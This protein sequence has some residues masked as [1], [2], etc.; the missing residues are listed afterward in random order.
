MVDSSFGMDPEEVYMD[1]RLAIDQLTTLEAS[2]KDVPESREGLKLPPRGIRR[3]GD[4]KKGGF[5]LNIVADLLGKGIEKLVELIQKLTG[6]RVEATLDGVN[7]LLEDTPTTTSRTAWA[8]RWG[9]ELTDP[10]VGGT[11]RKIMNVLRSA[12]ARAGANDAGMIRK[13]GQMV[14][15]SELS[16][17]GENGVLESR[18]ADSNYDAVRQGVVKYRARVFADFKKKLED[19]RN[20]RKLLAASLGMEEREFDN[21][22]KTLYLQLAEVMDRKIYEQTAQGLL[23]PELDSAS[24]RSLLA[25]VEKYGDEGIPEEVRQRVFDELGFGDDVDSSD[26][27]RRLQ[28]ISTKIKEQFDAALAELAEEVRAGRITVDGLD[29]NKV[30]AIFQ[31]LSEMENAKASLR[32][33]LPEGDELREALNSKNALNALDSDS[34]RDL[35][36]ALEGGEIERIIGDSVEIKIV[37]DGAEFTVIE[38]PLAKIVL[39]QVVYKKIKSG[40]RHIIYNLG[41][42]SPKEFKAF[43]KEHLSVEDLKAIYPRPEELEGKS[44][45]NIALIVTRE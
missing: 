29:M 20:S 28:Q 23:V 22:V 30:D 25:N 21:L 8:A 35:E 10:I 36:H 42:Y 4:P 44:I 38:S 17:M 13:L 5:A 27:A 31:H 1:P 39:G 26:F 18:S 3:P 19:I 41:T 16:M 12:R 40:A 32:D 14:F 45:D 15:G 33:L 6:R 34:F 9:T 43:I 24:L 37:E 2:R 11:A 7:R